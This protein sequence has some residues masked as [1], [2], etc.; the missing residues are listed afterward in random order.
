M[1]LSVNLEFEQLRG[2]SR[3]LCLLPERMASTAGVHLVL[4]ISERHVSRWTS[5]QRAIATDL[6]AAGIGLA[7]DDFGTG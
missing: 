7:V 6:A 3:L 5:P 4:E 1:S 2:D